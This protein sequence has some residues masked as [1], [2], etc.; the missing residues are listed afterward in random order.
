MEIFF[1]IITWCGSL[2]ILLPSNSLAALLL[3]RWQRTADAVL[4][5]GGLIGAS[6][7]THT[8][9]LL[10]ARPRPAAEYMLVGMPADFSFPSAHTAQVVACALASA[11]VFGKNVSGIKLGCLWMGAILLAILVGYSRLYLRVH[12]LSD[13]VA[14]AFL[15]G[16]W[17]LLLAK[18]LQVYR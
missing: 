18:I 15:G 4:L 11:L 1:K 9:K 7:M 5:L 16:I 8:L 10:F 13:V 6:I 17:V 3:V 12:Y 14:E 2:L